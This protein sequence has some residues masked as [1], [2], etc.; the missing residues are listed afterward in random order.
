MSLIFQEGQEQLNLNRFQEVEL[1]FDTPGSNI[2]R[3]SKIEIKADV[4]DWKYISFG[5]DMPFNDVKV[6]E[7]RQ[8]PDSSYIF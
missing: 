5:M 3:R 2:N 6:G 8:E 4:N 7:L 1:L